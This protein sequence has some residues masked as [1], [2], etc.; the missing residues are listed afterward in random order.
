M[1]ALHEEQYGDIAG[2]VVHDREIG[3]IV[4]HETFDAGAIDDRRLADAMIRRW[5]R[6]VCRYPVPR[7]D[8]EYGLYPSVAAFLRE[9]PSCS[10]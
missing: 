3:R 5:E 1:S 7:F 2:F 9:F 10:S 4:Y 6:L 8:V